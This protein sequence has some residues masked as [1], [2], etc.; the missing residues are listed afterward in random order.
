PGDLHGKIIDDLGNVV[1]DDV[2][3]L[4]DSNEPGANQGMGVFAIKPDSMRHYRLKID[5]PLGVTSE[6]K[7]PK[8]E[9]Q[10][11]VLNVRDG[12]TGPDDPIR[13]QVCS[14]RE[15][16]SLLVGAY[17]RG[18]LLD[19]QTVKVRQGEC[20]EV[21]LRPSAGAGGVYRITVFEEKAVAGTSR[22]ELL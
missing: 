1:V 19:H 15:D 6:H 20:S 11:V 18:R 21:V 8:A 5:T 16:K 2:H 22:R 3:T 17:C 13:V 10:G 9:Q 7:L 14:P 4:T 12:V